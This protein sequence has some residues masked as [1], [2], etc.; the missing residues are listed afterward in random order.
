M[1]ALVTGIDRTA[2]YLDDIWVT[3]RTFGKHNARLEAAFKG[4]QDYGFRVR[5]DKC[6]F[7]QTEITYLGFVIHAQGRRPI[8]K[9]SKIRKDPE[10]TR[11]E[12]CQSTSLFSGTHQFLRKIRQGSPQSTCSFGHLRKRMLSTHGH[13]SLSL[14]STRLRQS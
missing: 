6:A 12:R 4:I 3:G 10:D 1:D 5:F 13:R 7:L 9:R 2:A 8:Q 11:S 14:S